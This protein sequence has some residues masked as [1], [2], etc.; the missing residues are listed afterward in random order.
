LNITEYGIETSATLTKA[1]EGN[2]QKE[3]RKNKKRKGE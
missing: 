2:L 1:E 3:K